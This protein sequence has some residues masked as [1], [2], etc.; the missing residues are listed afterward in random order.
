MSNVV[1]LT[2]ADG[3]EHWA[4]RGSET[5]QRL[6]SG[7]TEGAGDA[8]TVDSQSEDHDTADTDGGSEHGS[9]DHTPADGGGGTRKGQ[10]SPGR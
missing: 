3:N 2:D 6:G 10:S 9:G 4:A 8:S 1:V 5:H 7:H